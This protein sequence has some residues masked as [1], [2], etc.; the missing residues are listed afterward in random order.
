M[1]LK[2]TMMMIAFVALASATP[3]RAWHPLFS[4]QGLI[5]RASNGGPV[6]SFILQNYYP[7]AWNLLQSGHANAAQALVWARRHM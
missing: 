1:N 4:A 7:N 6:A 2:H 3:A 5:N